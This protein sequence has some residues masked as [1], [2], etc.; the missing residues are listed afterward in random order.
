MPTTIQPVIIENIIPL[1]D[2]GL[3]QREMSRT[4]GVSQGAF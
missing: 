3:S 1:S 2:L 4:I